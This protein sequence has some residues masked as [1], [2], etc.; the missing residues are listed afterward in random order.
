LEDS[1]KDFARKYAPEDLPEDEEVR[2]IKLK[3]WEMRVK[4]YLDQEEILQENVNKL[5][6]LM[7]GQC[8]PALHSTIKAD[9][10]YEEK[11]KKFDA[12]WLMQKFKVIV[13]GIDLIANPALTLH[14]QVITFLQ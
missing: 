10:E 2:T 1:F 4:R 8:M 7:I 5:H 14:E 6:G 3:I 12:L 11:S 9:N 13:A